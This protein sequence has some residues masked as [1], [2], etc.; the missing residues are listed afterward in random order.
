MLSFLRI[1]F[2]VYCLFFIG[3]L[4]FFI[5]LFKVCFLSC[6]RNPSLLS[7]H[8]DILLYLFYIIFPF[9]FVSL[10]WLALIF[11]CD[12][13]IASYL[14]IDYWIVLSFHKNLLCSICH[15]S[16]FN[17]Y[18]HIF[19]GSLFCSFKWIFLFPSLSAPRCL[20]YYSFVIS[21]DSW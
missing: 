21:L 6:V 18:L 12:L 4:S 19:L 14:S 2:Y 7:G 11:A 1:A 17:I 3:C 9:T 15:T 8:K 10:I 16:S 20:N 5:Y 13:W